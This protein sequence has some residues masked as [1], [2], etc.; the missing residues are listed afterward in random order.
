MRPLLLTEADFAN[1]S[2]LAAHADLRR[3]LERANVV[4]MNTKLIVSDEAGERSVLRVVYPGDADPAR[5]ELVACHQSG[6]PRRLRIG[7]LIF[8][9]EQS[10]RSQLV[11]REPFDASRR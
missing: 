9:P 8:Q 11:V 2:L 3:R 4:T 7:E 10:L 6:R 5:G 1:P